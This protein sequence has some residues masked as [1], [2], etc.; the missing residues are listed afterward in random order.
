MRAT[1]ADR[2]RSHNKS[3]LSLGQHLLGLGDGLRR[4]QTLRAGLR[5]IHDRMAAIQA[6]RVL[7]FVEALTGCL[8]ARVDEPAIGREQRGRAQVA[9]A[10][11]PVAWAARRAT[12]AQDAG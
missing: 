6:E 10:V 11:P 2:V 9:I 5:A 3:I 12:G 8:V 4:V 7:E 1:I